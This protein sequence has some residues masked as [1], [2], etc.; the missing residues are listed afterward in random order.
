MP[1]YSIISEQDIFAGDYE[2]ETRQV[3]VDDGILT[4]IKRDGKFVPW[5]LFST[6]PSVYLK[7][8]DDFSP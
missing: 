7:N 1:I 4:L 8:T 3:R 5:S 6:N 2:I